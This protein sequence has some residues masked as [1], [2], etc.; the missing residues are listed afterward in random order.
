MLVPVNV[1]VALPVVALIADRILIFPVPFV[2]VT[3]FDPIELLAMAVVI[4]TLVDAFSAVLMNP[5][6]LA[7]MMMSNG[8]ISHIPPRPAL[9]V[10]SRFNV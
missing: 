10:P 3:E 1:N 6:M 7:S 9:I 5:A 2:P 4:D 8:S